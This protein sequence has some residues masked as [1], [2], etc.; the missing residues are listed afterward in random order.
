MNNNK[1]IGSR[2]K[3]F[4]ESK[5]IGIEDM[6]ER[7]G[8]GVDSIEQIEGNTGLT[9][10][11]SLIKISR[12]LG[13]RLGTFL[14]DNDELGPVISRK[15]DHSDKPVFS[16]NNDM[17]HQ[18]HMEYFPLSSAKSGRHMEPFIIQIDPTEEGANFIV[19]SHEGE[20]FIYCLDGIV[21][22]TYGKMT[23]LLEEGD[24]IY[25]DSIV[26]HHVHAAGQNGAKILAVVYTP[27]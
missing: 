17:G 23:Y 6:A 25:Y 19:S 2:I 15:K 4:R 7:S 14:D 5:H 24:S 22:I 12:V 27:F 20:E 8:L 16:M 1:S 11:A 18:K 3:S 13:V 21:E 9:S 26:P 10:L